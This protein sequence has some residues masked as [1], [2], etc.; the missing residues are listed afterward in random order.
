MLMARSLAFLDNNS[1]LA[2]LC[3]EIKNPG[4]RLS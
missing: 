3:V 2:E 1:L 4:E